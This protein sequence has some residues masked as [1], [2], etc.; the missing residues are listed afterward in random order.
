MVEQGGWEKSGI[1]KVN[2]MKFT[3]VKHANWVLFWVAKIFR[4]I[5]GTIHQEHTEKLTSQSRNCRN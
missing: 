1:E 3:Q 5:I 2:S 4:N